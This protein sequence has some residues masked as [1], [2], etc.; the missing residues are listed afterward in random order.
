MGAQR[1]RIALVPGEPGGVGPE[2]CVRLAAGETAGDLL[3][4]GDPRTLRHAAQ[5]LGLNL[6]LVDAGASSA[7]GVLPVLPVEQPAPARFGFADPENAASVIEALREAAHLCASGRAQGMVTGPIH[8]AS[9]NLGGIPYR[10]TTELL[11]ELA[12]CEVVM[13][14]ANRHMRVALVTTHLPLRDVADAITGTKIL[15]TLDIMHRALRTD[16]GIDRPRIV[17][18][19]LNPHAGESGHLGQE[20]LTIIEPALDAARAGGMDITGPLPADT[21]FLPHHVAAADAVLAMYHDQGLPVLK[22]S[23]FEHGVNM[24]LGLPYPRVAV[25][26][27]TALDLAGKGLADAGSLSEAEKL[28]SAFAAQRAAAT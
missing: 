19:G 6:E 14:L 7:P 10:G 3:A 22:Y 2:L 20:E 5:T 16:F 13:M 18:L 1:P 15:R 21:A 26:H 4:I 17:V 24:T 9:I 23:G 25:D 12:G 8:K 27:G 28:C 11:A